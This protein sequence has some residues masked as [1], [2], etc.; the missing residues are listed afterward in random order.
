[1]IELQKLPYEHNALEPSISKETLHYHYNK[2]HKAYVDNLNKLI[3]G[4][5]FADLSLEEIIKKS[6]S[7]P[8]F[9]NAAQ[10]WNHTFYWNSMIPTKEFE[11]LNEGRLY[12]A[13]IKQWK[14]FEAFEKEFV[15]KGKKLFGSGWVWLVEKN[16]NLSIEATHNANGPKNSPLVV[17]DIWEHAYYLDTK[18]ERPKYI[19]NFFKIVNWEFAKKNFK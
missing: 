3:K 11:E 6:D 8:I 4:T 16:G 12:D 1:M 2:H 17:C 5:E 9:N 15:E 13:I 19:E 14:T 18:N 7:G 10:V